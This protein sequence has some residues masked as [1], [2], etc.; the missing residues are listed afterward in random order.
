MLG[1]RVEAYV[2]RVPS[3]YSVLEPSPVESEWK[4]GAKSVSYQSVIPTPVAHSDYVFLGPVLR[5]LRAYGDEATRGIADGELSAGVLRLGS[6][7]PKIDF[8]GQ[9]ENR[10]ISAPEIYHT[11]T[12]I[13]ENDVA[14]HVVS[15]AQWGLMRI[16]SGFD[17]WYESASCQRHNPGSDRSNRL[18]LPTVHPERNIRVLYLTDVEGNWD[19]FCHFVAMTDGIWWEHSECPKN[20]FGQYKCCSTGAISESDASDALRLGSPDDRDPLAERNSHRGVSPSD[21][22]TVDEDELRELAQEHFSESYPH[23][24]L[25]FGGDACD[26]GPGC[27]RFVNALLQLRRRYGGVLVQFVFG[28]R[29]SEKLRYW[30]EIVNVGTV[31]AKIDV[32]ESFSVTRLAPMMPDKDKPLAPTAAGVLSPATAAV[33]FIHKMTRSNP[34]NSLEMRL[35]ELERTVGVKMK[36]NL[37]GAK[38]Q[39]LNMDDVGASF[40]LMTLPGSADGLQFYLADQAAILRKHFPVLSNTYYR[41]LMDTYKTSCSEEDTEGGNLQNVQHCP[42]NFMYQYIRDSKLAI[43]EHGILWTHSGPL[44]AEGKQALGNEFLSGKVWENAET[45]SKLEKLRLVSA[46]VVRAVGSEAAVGG[47]D[48][49]ESFIEDD[50]RA[51]L[52]QEVTLGATLFPV[53]SAIGVVPEDG[54]DAGKDTA[55]SNGDGDDGNAG[56]WKCGENVYASS[57]G[58]NWK[59][60]AKAG[61]VMTRT[62]IAQWVDDLNAWKDQK[63]SEYVTL[64]PQFLA[65]GRMTRDGSEGRAGDDVKWC[66]VMENSDWYAKRPGV[67]LE[68]YCSPMGRWPTVCYQT[69]PETLTQDMLAAFHVQYPSVSKIVVGHTPQGIAPTV[70]WLDQRAGNEEGDAGLV[71][72]RMD[73]S[74]S[75]MAPTHNFVPWLPKLR[76]SRT[77]K[78][79]ALPNGASL[80]IQYPKQG[81]THDSEQGAAFNSDD[82]K[83]EYVEWAEIRGFAPYVEKAETVKERACWSGMEVMPGYEVY[84]ASLERRGYLAGCLFFFC[85]ISSVG[86]I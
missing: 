6:G 25:Y 14:V 38:L 72:L 79:G 45:M 71:F 84:L 80:T 10:L 55:A 21:D 36:G 3:G 66:D 13:R 81:A 17:Y 15:H 67:V 76:T 85:G 24:S 58:W 62:D 50:V 46:S 51:P 61:Q 12:G 43:F 69:P 16:R 30:G 42:I 18:Q 60:P 1:I 57:R 39:Q 64:T 83:E 74:Y 29:D 68:S 23:Y 48:T 19:Y 28:N 8:P 5:S 75:R 37:E 63:M 47:S 11:K 86:G 33:H 54:L 31:H 53:F 78:R 4:W 82:E 70:D 26:N 9:P 65:E 20:R 27:M 41:Y 22:Y 52:T 59:S 2:Y 34:E 73:T 77:D 49:D 32:P 7:G 40:F 56:K 44:G 35:D